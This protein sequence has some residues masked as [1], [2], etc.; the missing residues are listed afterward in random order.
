[1]GKNSLKLGKEIKKFASFWEHDRQD[2]LRV[3]NS[4][5]GILDVCEESL[6]VGAFD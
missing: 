4:N 3:N 1:M 5:A 6:C 2:F